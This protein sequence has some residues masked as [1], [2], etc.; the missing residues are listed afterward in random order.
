MMEI[1]AEGMSPYVHRMPILNPLYDAKTLTNAENT[2]IAKCDDRSMSEDNKMKKVGEL[3]ADAM[4]QMG[5]PWPMPGTL[6]GNLEKAGFVDVEEV[7]FKQ[8]IGVWPKDKRYCIESDRDLD[9][10]PAALH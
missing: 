1:G 7:I 8:P 4:K 9:S 10:P 2:S 3:A 5:R 6:K